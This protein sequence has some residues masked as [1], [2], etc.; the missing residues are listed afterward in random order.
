MA[1]EREVVDPSNGHYIHDF[2]RY[3]FALS[4]VMGGNVLDVGCGSGYG[5]DL[6]AT[7]ARRVVGI[8]RSAEAIR[9]ATTHYRRPNLQYLKMDC[10]ALAFEDSSFDVVTS[11]DVLEHIAAEDTDGYLVEIVRVLR[12]QGVARWKPGGVQYRLNQLR[13]QEAK[14]ARWKNARVAGKPWGIFPQADASSTRC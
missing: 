9:Y 14:R 6:L 10:R 3:Y 1:N 2:A 8:D 11:L 12:P 5:A 13:Q 4:L 7:G